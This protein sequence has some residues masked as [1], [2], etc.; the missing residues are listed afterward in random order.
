MENNQQAEEFLKRA[1]DFAEDGNFTRALESLVDYHNEQGT[2]RNIL[3]AEAIKSFLSGKTVDIN[4]AALDSIVENLAV[5]RG[6]KFAITTHA[7]IPGVPE[8]SDTVNVHVG[9]DVADHLELAKFDENRDYGDTDRITV[10][11]TETG[12]TA[13]FHMFPVDRYDGKTEYAV[14]SLG[15]H[16]KPAHHWEH[17]GILLA[18]L[19]GSLNEEV[20]DIDSWKQEVH[21]NYP[22]HSGKMRFV[23]KENGKH[24]SAEVPGM[25]RSFGLYDIEK[26]QGHVLTESEGV[27]TADEEET[28]SGHKTR[29]HRITFKDDEDDKILESTE[30]EDEEDPQVRFRKA[31]K[32]VDELSKSMVKSHGLP[33]GSNYVARQNAIKKDHEQPKQVEEVTIVEKLKEIDGKWALVSEKDPTKVLQY[34]KGEGKPSD[35][36]VKKV[37]RRVHMFEADGSLSK[38]FLDLVEGFTEEFNADLAKKLSDKAQEKINKLKQNG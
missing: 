8:H 37:E 29:A 2:G 38:A 12:D 7:P 27:D 20:A 4:E 26:N 1:K 21:K 3:E 16:E 17:K 35:E 6:G 30:E 5:V 9:D 19:R 25:D 33:T 36:W 24:I 28:E 31:M 15:H 10:A 13:H 34:Y 18:H 14:R 32:A 23:S 22:E 11:N